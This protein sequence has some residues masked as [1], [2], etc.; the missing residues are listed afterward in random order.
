MVMA[1]SVIHAITVCRLNL[2]I[3]VPSTYRTRFP[4]FVHQIETQVHP[5]KTGFTP[6]H[7]TTGGVADPAGQQCNE[8]A[9]SSG[10]PPIPGIDM[11]VKPLCRFCQRCNSVGLATRNANHRDN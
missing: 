4:G 5:L 9:S 2:L 7:C 11:F 8:N 6:G 1:M 3:I 10:L